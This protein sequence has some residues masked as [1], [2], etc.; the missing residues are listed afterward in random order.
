MASKSR[1]DAASASGVQNADGIT[2]LRYQALNRDSYRLDSP[3]FTGAAVTGAGP[4]TQG[5]EQ[6]MP[7]TTRAEGGVAR[8]RT[9]HRGRRDGDVPRWAL[10]AR[11]TDGS[12]EIDET[13]ELD[14]ELDASQVVDETFHALRSPQT[15]PVPRQG[16]SMDTYTFPRHRFATQMRDE[17]KQP[18][19]VVACGSFSPPT[20][21]HL[22]V[23]D[24]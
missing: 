8:A 13:E 12:G 4:V 14:E 23:C 21:L 7:N 9:P 16:E 19:D 15:A 11:R 2:S 3:P 6:P 17:R 22:C 18:L 10:D 24:G 1:G 20:Y 5:L